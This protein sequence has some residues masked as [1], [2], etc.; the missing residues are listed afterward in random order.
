MKVFEPVAVTSSWLDAIL[1]AEGYPDQ[2]VPMEP[3]GRLKLSRTTVIGKP[4]EVV[5]EGE[6]VNVG[7][8]VGV[9]VGVNVI[10]GGCGVGTVG[11]AVSV[12]VSVS[13]AVGVWVTGAVSESIG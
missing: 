7:E 13:V 8:G 6:G 4:L 9:K 2:L 10:V 3:L 1:N 5:G 11:V 12:A